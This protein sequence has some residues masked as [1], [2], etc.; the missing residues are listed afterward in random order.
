[1]GSVVGW[2]RVTIFIASDQE[3]SLF[4]SWLIAFAPFVLLLARVSNAMTHS[5]SL[6]LCLW[7]IRYRDLSPSVGWSSIW[8]QWVKSAYIVCMLFQ[9]RLYTAHT[10]WR[11]FSGY[12]RRLNIQCWNILPV[13]KTRRKSLRTLLGFPDWSTSLC[14]GGLFVFPELDIYSIEMWMDTTSIYCEHWEKYG[15]EVMSQFS[16]VTNE[17]EADERWLSDNDLTSVKCNCN[18]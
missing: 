11:G 1:V 13:P 6:P 14:Y 12:E 16:L 17:S 5:T 3:E 18:W 15:T 9:L 7:R 10:V 4:L 2:L 8:S